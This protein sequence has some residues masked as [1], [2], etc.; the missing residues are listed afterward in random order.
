MKENEIYSL[1]EEMRDEYH[2]SPYRENI[3]FVNFVKDGI[4]DIN[5]YV[6]AKIDYSEDLEARRLLKNYVLYADY[7]KLSEFKELYIEKYDKLQRDYYINSN[8]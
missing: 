7:Q 4:Y 1:I 8:I 6:G 5:N 3:E 2:F